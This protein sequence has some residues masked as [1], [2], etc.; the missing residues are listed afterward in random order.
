M[1]ATLAELGS[2]LALTVAA[3]LSGV[4]VPGPVFAAAVAKGYENRLA[5]VW[6]ALGHGVVEFPLMILLFLGF[7]AIAGIPELALAVGVAGGIVLL[8]LGGTTVL[9]RR[10]A[11][12]TPMPHHPLLLGILTTA[13]NPYFFIWWGTVGLGLILR[14]F[15]FAFVG[16]LAFT[17]AHW[18]CD[19]GWNGFVSAAV[20]R[21]RRFW[22]DRV[23]EAVSVALG[24]FLLLLGGWFVY[25]ALA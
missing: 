20:H 25:A 19:L 13:A 24:A 1:A 9:R 6:I 14:V 18:G 7:A 22:D 15:P 5:G 21:T 16:F 12:S 11:G 17:V 10:Q 2:V 3:S 23:R 4:M 8:Y